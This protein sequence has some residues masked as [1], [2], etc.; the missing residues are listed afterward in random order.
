MKKIL[1]VLTLVSS[2]TFAQ[3]K[4]EI[5]DIEKVTKAVEDTTRTSG[6]VKK[7]LFT[8]LFINQVLITG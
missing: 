1:L 4:Q 3:T 7:G 2:L 5:K 6:W 8:T